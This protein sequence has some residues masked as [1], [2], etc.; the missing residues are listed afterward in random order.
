MDR[1]YEGG[2]M[3]PERVRRFALEAPG[4]AGA[5]WLARL[6]AIVDDCRRRWLRCCPASGFWL[7]EDEGCGWER[8]LSVADALD[9]IGR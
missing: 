6:P 9:A 8:A 7:L 1:H 4:Q 2:H 5:D 3:I